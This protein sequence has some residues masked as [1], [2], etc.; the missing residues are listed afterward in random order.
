MGY[1][2]ILFCAVYKGG[3]DISGC[4]I[5]HGTDNSFNRMIRKGGIDGNG[6]GTVP[7]FF[8]HRAPALFQLPMKGQKNRP[9]TSDS[10]DG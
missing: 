9:L 7:G 5:P 1:D 6:Q 8:R 10:I 4:N 2:L 3:L